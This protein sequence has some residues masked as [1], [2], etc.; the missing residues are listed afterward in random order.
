MEQSI[1]TPPIAERPQK[2]PQGNSDAENF[3][4]QILC[5]VHRSL[6]GVGLSLLCAIIKRNVEERTYDEN[7]GIEELD[8]HKIKC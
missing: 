5:P 4:N 1:L 7:D 6:D 2:Y 8:D 3:A